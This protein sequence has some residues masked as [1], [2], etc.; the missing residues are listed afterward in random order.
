MA[1]D[2]KVLPAGARALKK[3]EARVAVRLASAIDSL[4]DDPRPH[5]VK[6]LE[7][8]KDLYRVRVGPYRIIYQIHDAKLLIVVVTLGHRRDVYR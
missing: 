2:I 7:G 4:A 6:K 8:A 3:L 1:Y 5:G